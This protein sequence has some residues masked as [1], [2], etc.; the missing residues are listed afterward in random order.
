MLQAHKLFPFFMQ[1]THIGLNLKSSG[2]RTW[3][4][5][6]AVAMGLGRSLA[7]QWEQRSFTFDMMLM[8]PRMSQPRLVA[9]SL[10]Y[11]VHSWSRSSGWLCSG[12]GPAAGIMLM[13]FFLSLANLPRY[14]DPG[15]N[16]THQLPARASTTLRGRCTFTIYLP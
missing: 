9:N 5:Q 11:N 1:E 12:T 15:G 8:V 14:F 7:W 4:V 13:A 16:S 3:V 2:H 6:A 10:R